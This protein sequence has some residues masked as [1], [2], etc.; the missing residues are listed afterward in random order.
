MES[1]TLRHQVRDASSVYDNEVVLL[2]D[3]ALADSMDNLRAVAEQLG[4]HACGQHPGLLIT[5][6][7][8]NARL[9]ATHE[10]DWT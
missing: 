4:E 7:T 2:V 8:E 10:C 5:A 3:D 9:S 6:M 1:A